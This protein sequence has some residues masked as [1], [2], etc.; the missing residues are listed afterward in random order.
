MIDH[1]N[2]DTRAYVAAAAPLIGLHL[3]DERLD[4]VAEAFALVIR[5]AKPA[6]DAA[7][8]DDSQPAPVFVA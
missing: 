5:I 4:Q 2:F 6:L 8:P 1:E 7:V 3:S